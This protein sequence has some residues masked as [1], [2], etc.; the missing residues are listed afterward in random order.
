MPPYSPSLL[1]QVLEC[2]NGALPDRTTTWEV[3]LGDRVVNTTLKI[4]AAWWS[5]SGDPNTWPV[6]A[7]VATSGTLDRL[8]QLHSQCVSWVGPLSAAIYVPLVSEPGTD[9]VLS[10]SHQTALR[11]AAARVSAPHHCQ[12]TDCPPPTKA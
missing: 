9:G 12:H 3:A 11:S 2:W 1:L 5:T 6:Q 7:T 10:A 4:A 8:G